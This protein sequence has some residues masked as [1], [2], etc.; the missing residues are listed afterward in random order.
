MKYIDHGKHIKG[1]KSVK[2]GLI[3]SFISIIVAATLF[4]IFSQ[5]TSPLSHTI[6]I[7]TSASLNSA[8]IMT[9]DE[10]GY[11]KKEGIS[12]DLVSYKSA[13]A[14]FNDMLKGNIQLAAVSETPIMYKRFKTNDFHI[15]A[16]LSTSSNDPK[17][18]IRE[19][20]APPQINDLTGMRIGTTKQGQSA[21]FFLYL[22]LLKNNIRSGTVTTV[23][24]SPAG[25]VDRLVNGDIS[26]ASLFEPYA[27]YA[28]DR[29]KEKGSVFMMPGVYSKT[30]NLVAHPKFITDNP[31]AVKR[32]LRALILAE[33][34]AINQPE[35][36][37]AIITRNFKIENRIV[38]DYLS[39]SSFEI[40]LH[41]SLIQTM[42]DEAKW[43][44]IKKLTNETEVPDFSK[45]IYPDPLRSI[46]PECVTTRK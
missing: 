32:F 25:I 1:A 37:L 22:F 41:S 12:V 19:D 17:I 5:G 43:A 14:A 13:G 35:K 3:L 36:F 42:R 9:A 18:V 40:S 31:E 7:G 8:L 11:F 4:L 46:R 6:T 2:K 27:T 44:I 15:L 24:D 16:T 26:A 20:A 30:F 33:H 39:Y 28:L 23:H 34:F 10:N 45:M 38:N 29:L 21:H